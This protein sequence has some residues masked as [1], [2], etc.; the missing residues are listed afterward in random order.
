MVTILVGHMVNSICRTK[1]LEVKRFVFVFVT[2]L[3]HWLSTCFAFISQSSSSSSCCKVLA[4]EI[5]Q[6]S[7]LTQRKQLN[8]QVLGKFLY[9]YNY[10]NP[11][12][13]LHFLIVISSANN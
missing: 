8:G 9:A 12:F 5:Q 11:A 7:L 10:N 2:K 4:D 13:G 6:L 1:L 3:K